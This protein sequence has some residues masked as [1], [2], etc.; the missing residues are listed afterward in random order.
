MS[1]NFRTKIVFVDE[2][3]SIPGRKKYFQADI[4]A[5]FNHICAIYHPEIRHIINKAC[6]EY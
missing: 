2:I 4:L 5:I 6:H 1:Q 3:T